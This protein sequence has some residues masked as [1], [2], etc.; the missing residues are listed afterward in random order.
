ME[1]SKYCTV[2]LKRFEKQFRELQTSEF[3][4]GDLQTIRK[5]NIRNHL[6]DFLIKR[7]LKNPSQFGCLK[8]NLHKEQ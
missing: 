7:N 3:N 2:I 5:T 4:I 1:T 6:I 8:A